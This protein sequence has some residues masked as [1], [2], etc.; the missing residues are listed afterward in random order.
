[1]ASDDTLIQV[2]DLIKQ[3]SFKKLA[4]ELRIKPGSQPYIADFNG[5]FLQD[6]MFTGADDSL[7][8]VAY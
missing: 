2:Y 4:F 7:I 3:E 5:D 1:V 6:I 8:H